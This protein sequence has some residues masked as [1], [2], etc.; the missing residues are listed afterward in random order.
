M[1]SSTESLGVMFTEDEKLHYRCSVCHA[2]FI[3]FR[4]FE[5][6]LEIAGIDNYINMLER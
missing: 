5:K 1:L 3:P 4:E 2:T 6:V